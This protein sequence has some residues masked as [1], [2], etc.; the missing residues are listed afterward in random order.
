MSA[1]VIICATVTL[2]WFCD[3][4]VCVKTEKELSSLPLLLIFALLICQNYE[5][6][7]E[8]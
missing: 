2:K 7:K 8:K 5:K 3:S 1:I 4:W 6:G